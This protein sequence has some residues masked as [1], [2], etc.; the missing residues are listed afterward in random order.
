MSTLHERFADGLD[1]LRAERRALVGSHGDDVVSEITVSQIVGGMRGVRGLVCD[2]SEV[3][4]DTGLIIRGR[5]VLDLIGH[6]PEDIFHLLLTGELPSPEERDALASELATRATVPEYVWDTL[7]AMPDDSHPMSMLSAG[8]VT[9]ERKS[10]FRSRFSEGLDRADYWRVALDDA[11]D[12]M[13]MLPALG[14]GV[15]RIRYDKGAPIPYDP[16]HDWAANYCRMLGVEDETFDAAMRIAMILQ[17]DHEGGNV[18]AFACHTVASVLSNAYLAVAAGFNGLAG[19]LHGLASQ[20]ST[21]WV[22]AAVKLYGGAPTH[23][24]IEEYTWDTLRAGRFVPGYGH[25][26]LRALDPRFT[27]MVDFGRKH[28]DGDDVFD[29]VV[30]MADVV[31]GVLKTHGKAKNPYPN[32]DAGMGAVWRHFGITELPYYTVPFAVSLA[33]GMLAQLVINRALGSP[34]VRPRSV[35]TAWLKKQVGL[36]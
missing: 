4:P 6:R 22:L 7:R 9:L 31:P 14:A 33:V 2:T 29:T 34:I 25:A 35:T 17:C 23:E 20:E 32:V 30:R 5:P 26:V 11:L 21:R 16:G 28:F 3:D 8:V 1:E 27:A 24:Q 19:P 36:D 15:Y 18:C 12:L 10:E 13:A